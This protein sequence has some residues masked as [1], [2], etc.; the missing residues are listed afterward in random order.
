MLGRKLGSMLRCLIAL[1][2]WFTVVATAAPAWTWTDEAG[3]THISDRPVPGATQI[4]LLV[5]RGPTSAPA[6]PTPPGR[7]TQQGQPAVP[8]TANYADFQIVSPTQEETLW[9]IGG[10]LTMRVAVLPAIQPGHELDV[11]YDGQHLEIGAQG[12]QMTIPDV[13][14]GLHTLQAV[15]VQSVSRQEVIRSQPV[16]IMVQQTRIVTP[17][18]AASN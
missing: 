18:N 4:E 15:I 9:N 14:R 7:S 8:Q 11:I 2:F 1:S 13:V 5:P 6:T 12:P 17:N 10:N 3:R 16:T